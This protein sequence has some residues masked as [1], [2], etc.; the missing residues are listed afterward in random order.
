MKFPQQQET[1]KKSKIL[2]LSIIFS[3][4]ISRLRLVQLSNHV[5][6]HTIP[7]IGVCVIFRGVLIQLQSGTLDHNIDKCN[8]TSFG[9][10]FLFFSLYNIFFFILFKRTYVFVPLF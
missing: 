9:S 2:I 8:F 10:I 1:L 7:E 6:I 4:Y 5:L 3:F